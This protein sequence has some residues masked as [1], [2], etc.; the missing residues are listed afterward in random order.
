MSSGKRP[1]S[2]G[3]VGLVLAG[4]RST[5][6]GADKLAAE[7]DGRPLLHHALLA[8]AQVSPH[9]LLSL[10]ADAPMPPLPALAVPIRVVHDRSD[11]W[12]PLAGIGAGLDALEAEAASS[13]H[14]GLPGGGA[15]LLVVAGDMPHLAASLL[16]GLV[17]ALGPGDAA[18][19]A[20]AEGWRPLPCVVRAEAAGP[21]VRARLVGPDRSIR[22]VLRSLGPAIVSEAVWRTWDPDGAWRGDVD[23]PPDLAAARRRE[24]T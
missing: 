3:L 14:P 24:G 15:T 16:R 6:F 22:G 10:G 19:L 5:R 13:L 1:A 12:G 4:G 17:A 23:R 20:D 11:E 2:A 21:L 9:V 18:V 8:V 7:L